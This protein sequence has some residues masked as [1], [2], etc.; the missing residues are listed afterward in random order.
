MSHACV[1]AFGVIMAGFSTGLYYIGISMGYLY[2]LMGVI[3]SSAVLP[4]AL[5]LLWKRM[6]WQAA[7][8]S[9]ILGLACS[10]TAWLVTCKVQYGELNVENTGK[11]N[12]MLGKNPDVALV[13]S[14]SFLNYI[15]SLWVDESPSDGY[16]STGFDGS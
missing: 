1:V 12:P 5:T 14:W 7:V 4:A 15:W 11:N 3:V 2:L 10:L 8:F 9:P 16:H 13:L 6:N